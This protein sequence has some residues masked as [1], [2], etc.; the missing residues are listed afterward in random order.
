[1]AV[2]NAGQSKDGLILRFKA[3]DLEQLI[4]VNLKSAFYLCAAV[5][6]PMLKQR[7]GAIVRRFLDRR[8]RRQ[9]GSERLRRRPRRDYLV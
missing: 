5:A 2:A 6:K 1:V 7:S 9:P 8:D 4:D 3:A